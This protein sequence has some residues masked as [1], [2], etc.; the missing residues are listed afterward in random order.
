M[1]ARRWRGYEVHLAERV[2]GAGLESVP[3][4]LC[5]PLDEQES[6]RLAEML[7]EY[8]RRLGRWPRRRIAVVNK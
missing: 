7:F 3:V 6:L 4:E 5:R 1:G 2:A 8:G